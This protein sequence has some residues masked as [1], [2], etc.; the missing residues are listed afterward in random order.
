MPHPDNSVVRALL[1]GPNGQE[2]NYVDTPTE[3]E[4]RAYLNRE[5][6]RFLR[7]FDPSKYANQDTPTVPLDRTPLEPAQASSSESAGDVVVSVQGVYHRFQNK[8]QAK[9]FAK[10]LPAGSYVIRQGIKAFRAPSTER[11]S[12]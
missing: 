11:P 1:A 9:A 12:P 5:E 6:A 4:R 7:T 3:E 2:S 10:T 8:R